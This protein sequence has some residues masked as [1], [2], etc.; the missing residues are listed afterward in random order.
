MAAKEIDGLFAFIEECPTAFHA[1]AALHK[2]FAD[3][4]FT[5]LKEQEPWD[6]CHG[7]KY[8]V[9]RNDSSFISFIVPKQEISGY[10]MAASH[11][12]SPSFKIKENPEI[13]AEGAYVKLNTEKYGGVIWLS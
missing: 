8:F 10:H 11:T 13:E 6:I 3:A 12:D 7:G 9:K 2:R 1:V 5:E 4:G